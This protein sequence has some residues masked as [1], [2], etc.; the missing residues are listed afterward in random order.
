MAKR[1]YV[2]DNHFGTRD[3]LESIL[4]H[5]GHLVQ[6]V[7]CNTNTVID[8]SLP[9]P[10]LILL[11]YSPYCNGLVLCQQL[12]AQ[13]ATQAIPVIILSVLPGAE[14]KAMAAGANAFIEKPFNLNR[15]ATTINYWAGSDT[16]TNL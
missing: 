3:V 9:L 4:T 11:D 8:L 5:L 1:L 7:A 12:K 2:V 13:V 10:H 14:A 6:L 16:E 15:I